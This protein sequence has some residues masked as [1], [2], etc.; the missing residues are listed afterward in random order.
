MLW[1]EGRFEPDNFSVWQCVMSLSVS[2]WNI[3]KLEM[4][5][6]VYCDVTLFVFCL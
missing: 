6:H 4:I 1:R 2:D 3:T 5:V